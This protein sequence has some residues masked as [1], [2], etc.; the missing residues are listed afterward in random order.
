MNYSTELKE[1]SKIS[2]G[3][4]CYNFKRRHLLAITETSLQNFCVYSSSLKYFLKNYYATGVQIVLLKVCFDQEKVYVHKVLGFKVS[5]FWVQTGGVVALFVLDRFELDTSDIGEL[6]IEDDDDGDGEFGLLHSLSS[7]NS[8][9]GSHG[10]DGCDVDKGFDVGE[11]LCLE[12]FGVLF[13]G[14]SAPFTDGVI[15]VGGSLKLA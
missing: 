15:G 9:V 2:K 14:R 5:R 13:G 12:P 1:K 11:W 3:K 4:N 6:I 8:L 10:D 7:P